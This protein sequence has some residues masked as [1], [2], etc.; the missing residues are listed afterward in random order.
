MDK[1][2]Q[3]KNEELLPVESQTPAP[4]NESFIK[5]ITNF[6]KMF[7]KVFGVRAIYSL[8]LLLRQ[9][10]KSILKINI[11]NILKT[12]F[13][14]ANIRTSTFVAMLP[15]SYKILKRIL[16]LFT[17]NK[18]SSTVIFFSAFLSA[19]ISICLEEKTPLVTY[20]VLAI[21]VRVVHSLLIMLCK[22]L[23]ILQNPG[24][25]WDYFVFL[26]PAIWMMGVNYLNPGYMPITKLFDTYACYADKS[27]YEE[28]LRFRE[29]MRIV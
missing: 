2:N 29:Q 3:N 19:F 16:N 9:G 12:I 11:K 24:K 18:D 14:G 8:F 27:E 28:Q 26:G 15:L 13:S 7:L 21:M 17:E 22:K 20:I 10:K 23:N 4:K 25:V 5:L 1:V 6:V